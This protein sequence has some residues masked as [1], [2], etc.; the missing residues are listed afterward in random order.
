MRVRRLVSARSCPQ[1]AR[2][3]GDASGGAT[4]SRSA[5]SSTS[6]SPGIRNY[7][8]YG[9]VGVLVYD[10]DHGHR[11]VKRIPTFD[12]AAGTAAGERQRHRRH[13]ATGRLYITTPKRVAASI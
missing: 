2:R 6:R 3:A 8:E 5:I 9:G 13:A 12:V 1:R 4:R 10:I 11:F 7:V